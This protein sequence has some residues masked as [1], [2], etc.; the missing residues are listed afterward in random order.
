MPA[1]RT[2]AA[3]C[4]SASRGT[5]T[6]TTGTVSPYW[7]APCGRTSSSSHDIGVGLGLP[8]ARRI[9]EAHGGRIWV[10]SVVGR[11]S[12]FAFVLP[13]EPPSAGEAE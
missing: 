2:Q 8:I 7:A 1:T 6:A 11:G 9:V 3:C 4:S 13:A 12:T 10:E 5:A